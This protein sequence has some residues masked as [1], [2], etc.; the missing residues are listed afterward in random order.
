VHILS[1]AIIGKIQLFSLFA[2]LFKCSDKCATNNTFVNTL[3]RNLHQ[4]ISED[5]CRKSI[6]CK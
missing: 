3:V 4:E 2:V 6:F 5:C 1:I